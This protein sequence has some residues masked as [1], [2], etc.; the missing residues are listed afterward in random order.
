MACAFS[1]VPDC[2]GCF[3]LLEK[4]P[5]HSSL[6]TFSQCSLATSR[7]CGCAVN[8]LFSY[9]FSTQRSRLPA[10]S[11]SWKLHIMKK[12]WEIRMRGANAKCSHTPVRSSSVKKWGVWIGLSSA[13]LCLYSV[14]IGM[15]CINLVTVISWST[16]LPV[17]LIRPTWICWLQPCYYYEIRRI[18]MYI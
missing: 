14:R 11:W 5:P 2:V 7:R 17:T 12:V 3:L 8:N 15:R 16:Q 13:R 1:L 6:N 10:A 9:S 18:Y 4:L